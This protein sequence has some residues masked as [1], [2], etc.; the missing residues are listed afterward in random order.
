MSRGDRLVWFD[1]HGLHT[2]NDLLRYPTSS[3]PRD[4]ASFDS[5]DLC[6][7]RS[8]AYT[9][10]CADA[11]MVNEAGFAE[12]PDQNVGTMK[13]GPDWSFGQAPDN[14]P[15]DSSSQ[16]IPQ[17]WTHPPSQ[18]ERG[19]WTASQTR[20]TT[21]DPL[22]PSNRPMDET[23]IVQ[24]SGLLP[25]TFSTGHTQLPRL[26]EYQTADVPPAPIDRSDDLFW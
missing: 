24:P 22:T 20:D 2:I 5:D 13:W 3:A 12:G 18:V 6:S 14:P 8:T 23:P 19:T 26:G 11:G 16:S 21:Y 10:G 17:Y 1:K 15:D 25:P 9:D 4:A 7:R